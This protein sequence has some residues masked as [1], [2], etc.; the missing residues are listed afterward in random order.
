MIIEYDE[1]NDNDYYVFATFISIVGNENTR[2]LADNLS[3]MPLEKY[4]M[5]FWN[6]DNESL[7]ELKM[8]FLTEGKKFLSKNYPNNNKQIQLGRSWY[9][10]TSP[11][12]NIPV[13]HHGNGLFTGTFYI[14][15]CDSGGNLILI[16][17]R[18]CVPTADFYNIA[19]I[20]KNQSV[21][22]IKPKKGNLVF[23]PN[24][25]LHYVDTNTSTKIRK[26]ISANYS[27]IMT[28]YGKEYYV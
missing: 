18:G 8:L 23:F 21:I 10:E 28:D 4:A 11:N 12:K 19:D 7:H 27:I 24:Y 14:D 22:Y 2:I 17:P 25:I 26:S 13:H 5:N 9:N 1:M 6:T 20:K 3:K 16:D 15:D